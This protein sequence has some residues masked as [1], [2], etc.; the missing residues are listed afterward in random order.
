MRPLRDGPLGAEHQRRRE[1]AGR[2][3]RGAV[4]VEQRQLAVGREGLDVVAQD[5]LLLIQ[6]QAGVLQVRGD[7]GEQV[8][9]VIEVLLD[10]AG[11]VLGRGL[12]FFGHRD[13]GRRPQQLQRHHAVGEQRRDGRG[14][15]EH[16]EAGAN[17]LHG[18][19]A[20]AAAAV[21]Q[22][23]AIDRAEDVDVVA[24]RQDEAA[25]HGAAGLP[26]VEERGRRI[27]VHRALQIVDG[28]AQLVVGARRAH[29]IEDGIGAGIAG[30]DERLRRRAP[31]HVGEAEAVAGDQL[32][33]EGVEPAAGD[34]RP[35]GARSAPPRAACRRRRRGAGAGSAGP[36]ARSADRPG[37]GR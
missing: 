25:A 30:T 2:G 4:A 8:D 17:R 11:G 19:P 23:P 6:R 37:P 14:R 21:D 24:G 36:G 31:Q 28:L 35:E 3:H 10:L 29:P 12:G 15:D 18:D 20:P 7:R 33:E 32:A 5:P 34:A 27:V 22:P 1:Q 13:V 9:V 26:P 16:G